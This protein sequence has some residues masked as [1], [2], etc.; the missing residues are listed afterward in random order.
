MFVILK[1]TAWMPVESEEHILGSI[2]KNPLSPSSDY[3]PDSPLQYN[4]YNLLET[5]G[6]DFSL[7]NNIAGAREVSGSVTQIA[8]M[9]VKG[10]D[11]D[12]IRLQG[13]LVRVKRLQ[14][15]DTFWN[16][17]RS[18]EAVKT[19]VPEWLSYSRQDWPVCMVVGIMICEDVEHGRNTASTT[20]LQA[21]G[22]V[23]VGAIVN[24]AGG[25]VPLGDAA[26]PKLAL[27]KSR[28]ASTSFQA[29]YET[30]KIF[31]V[32]LREVTSRLFQRKKLKLS[33]TG[34]GNIDPARLADIDLD[35]NEDDDRKL[36]EPV[37]PEDLILSTWILKTST[38]WQCDWPMPT[39]AT[40][41]TSP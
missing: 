16:A 36:Y 15:V 25:Y 37:D 27:E 35:D 13:K 11:E 39:V 6:S 18:D 23:P 34:P 22:K 30:G 8:N 38:R 20:Q 4:N 33:N 10:T 5:T 29:K 41:G 31:A 7:A 19:Q 26:D 28:E 17:L 21:A 2:I 12:K 24:A 32:E 14:K 40:T 9:A 3:V 1:H